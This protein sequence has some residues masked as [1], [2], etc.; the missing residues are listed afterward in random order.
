M[1]VVIH[2]KLDSEN[3]K[4]N[5]KALLNLLELIHYIFSLSLVGFGLY[6]LWSGIDWYLK[7]DRLEYKFP[8]MVPLVSILGIFLSYYLFKK[9]LEAIPES[10]ELG[11]KVTAYYT[12]SLVKFACLEAPGFLALFAAQETGNIIYLAFAALVMLFLIIGRPTKGKA[13][14]Q[15]KL[16]SALRQELDSNL[17]G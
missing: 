17:N 16:S 1:G 10:S 12:A 9:Q 15:L 8:F 5:P 2:L 3:K 4:A 14:R 13:I 6:L 11:S 7:L